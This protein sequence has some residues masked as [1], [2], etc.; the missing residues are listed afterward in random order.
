MPATVTP[1]KRAHEFKN[2]GIVVKGGKLICKHCGYAFK[3]TKKSCIETHVESISHKSQ[4]NRN[5]TNRELDFS[6]N[7]VQDDF[8]K[9]L[10]L[11]FARTNIPLQKVAH[12]ELR[13]FVNRWTKV[14]KR[15]L[16]FKIQQQQ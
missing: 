14:Y 13:K 9:D 12:P 6:V 2:E 10:V 16:I 3:T 11:T 4:A 5:S 15:F 8:V 1:L 7:E